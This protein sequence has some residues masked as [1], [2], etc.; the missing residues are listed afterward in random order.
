MGS[1]KTE[2][3]LAAEGLPQLLRELAEALE[4]GLARGV[5]E[6]LPA[7]GYRKLVLVAE[8]RDTGLLLRLK[9][10]RASEVRVPT[11]AKS[12]RTDESGA[13]QRD[14]ARSQAAREK[15]RQLKKSLQADFKAMRAACG[16]GRLPGAETVESFLSLAGLMG[17]GGQP[18]SGAALAE[19]AR[20]NTMF[21]DDCQALRRACSARDVAA[22]GA[23][24]E[25]LARRKSAC[26]AQFR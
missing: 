5:L 14:K 19:L 10:R 1:W 24:L 9:A 7:R 12:V 6:G 17:Q 3:E 13:T 23:V 8:R 4:T 11:G 20:S 16:E 15:Y 26:H 2:R 21:L 18:A 22:L 25:R